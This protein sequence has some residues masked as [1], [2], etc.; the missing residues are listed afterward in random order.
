MHWLSSR[1]QIGGTKNGGVKSMG[2]SENFDVVII[3]GAIMGT[4]AS[5]ALPELSQ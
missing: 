3:G 2:A 4:C 1:T 5:K